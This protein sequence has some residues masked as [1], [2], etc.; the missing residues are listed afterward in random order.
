M[1]RW[2][3]LFLLL[4][5][6]G[7]LW[8]QDLSTLVPFH[9]SDIV[10]HHPLAQRL[11]A[12]WLVVP[13][14]AGGSRWYDLIGQEHGTLLNMTAGYGFQPTR[15]AGW[16]GEMRFDGIDDYV[17]GSTNTVFDFPDVTFTVS[18]RYRAVKLA[19]TNYLIAKRTTSGGWY[20]RVNS[21]GTLSG[22]VVDVANTI[23]GSRDT[24]STVHLDGNWR[25]VTV[26]FVVDTVTAANNDVGIYVNGV[27]DQGTRFN[28]GGLVAALCACG[29]AFGAK[30]DGDASQILEGSVD[31]IRI[32]RGALPLTTIASLS[33]DRP[34]DFGGLV[35]PPLAPAFPASV[36]GAPSR[37]KF[38]PFFR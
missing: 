13:H 17:L 16:W 30:S 28:S 38:F 21:D 5:A 35:Q 29:L 23:A 12:W 6:V 9:P 22:V 20:I 24:V 27:L 1:R 8:G 32:W 36:A 31:D 3:V 14:L 33:L 25:Q 2:L 34:P 7:L 11:V 26:I 15:R 18:L 4:T 10:V 37:G 19:A